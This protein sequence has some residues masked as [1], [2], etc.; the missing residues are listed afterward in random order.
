MV[1]FHPPFSEPPYFFFLSLKY[2]CSDLKHLNQALVLL[3]YYKNSPPI[4]KSWI[5]AWTSISAIANKYD[6]P[7][8]VACVASVSERFQSTERG[9]RLRENGA[10][11]R[12]GRGWRRKVRKRCF[13]SSPFPSPLSFFGSCSISRAAKTK[14][15][16]PRSFF[17]LKP[18]WSPC[19][20]DCK[21]CYVPNGPFRTHKGQAG[22]YW[23]PAQGGRGRERRK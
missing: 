3:H 13:L 8:Y 6:I 1:K 12:A 2:W 20:A 14:N 18:N 16:I 9:T 17:A 21:Q 23:P 22:I 10:S 4:S 11:K 7:N 15:P 5:R 19:Y